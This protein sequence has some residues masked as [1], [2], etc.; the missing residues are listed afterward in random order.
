[1]NEKEAFQF[2][3]EELEYYEG[4]AYPALAQRIGQS[5]QL[6]RAG[7]NGTAYQL[8]IQ[9]MWDAKSEGAIRVIASIDDG[10]WRAF[11]PLTGSILKHPEE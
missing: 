10:R 7:T 6:E 9:I 8:E 1:M 3:A 11:L 4:I 2:L 5:I